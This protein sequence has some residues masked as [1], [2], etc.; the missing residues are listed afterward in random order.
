MN[1]VH[2]L[3]VL[4]AKKNTASEDVGSEVPT[5]IAFN[6][7]FRHSSIFSDILSGILAEALRG[8]GSVVPQHAGSIET[9]MISYVP[10]W[11]TLGIRCDDVAFVLRCYVWSWRCQMCIYVCI[12]SFSLSCSVCLSREDFR[13]VENPTWQGIPTQFQML[14]FFVQ[15]WRGF[16][17]LIASRVS[18]QDCQEAVSSKSSSASCHRVPKRGYRM[19]QCFTPP[20]SPMPSFFTKRRL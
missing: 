1:Y 16:H 5:P 10:S 8:F 20:A 18:L 9:H 19:T 13:I 3:S 12:L 15:C 6:L 4:K 14:R 11:S 17:N 7:A 2:Y